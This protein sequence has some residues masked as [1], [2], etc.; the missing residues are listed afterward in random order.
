[1]KV[2]KVVKLPVSL[3]NHKYISGSIL[4]RLLLETEH[5]STPTA[6]TEDMDVEG[7]SIQFSIFG[8]KLINIHWMSTGSEPY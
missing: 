5:G 8:S 6:Y 2:S 7:E 4:D 3:N 1:M